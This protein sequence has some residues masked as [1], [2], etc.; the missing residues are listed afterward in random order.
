MQWPPIR[1]IIPARNGAI[2]RMSDRLPSYEVRTPSV[3]PISAADIAVLIALP[4]LT[5]FAWLCPARSWQWICRGLAPIAAHFLS[6]EGLSPVQRVQQR[7]GD[8]RLSSAADVITREA[9]A[10]RLHTKVVAPE[11]F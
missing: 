2:W 5:C 8:W 1:A 4:A 10:G 11:N 6:R 9:L 3:K 7:L